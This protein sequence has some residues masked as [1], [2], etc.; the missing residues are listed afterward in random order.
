MTGQPTKTGRGC[1]FYGGI[2]AAVLLL[3]II[4]GGIVGV[5]QAKK[6]LADFTDPTPQLAP[7]ANATPAETADLRKRVDD[8]R[9]D[10]RAARSPAPLSVSPEDINKLIASDPD[11]EPL[12]GRLFVTAFEGDKIK[13][14]ISFPLDQLG[15][16]IFRG[17]FLNGDGTFLISLRGGLLYLKVQDI[18]VR[19][20][21]IPENYMQ[22][23]RAQNLAKPLNGNP[24]VSV[25]L[26][27]LKSI[28]IKDGRLVIA[29]A[30]P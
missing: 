10:V 13:A 27:K 14:R 23:I 19:G 25:A 22:V 30:S 15:L 11:L 1:L 3:L 24:R 4:A 2:A 28:E 18:V 5:R 12:K 17:R 20:K 21:P 7:V 6:M 8:F 9:N 29:P 16:P 26:D